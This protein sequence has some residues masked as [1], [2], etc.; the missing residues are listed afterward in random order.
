[1]DFMTM[2]LNQA[3]GRCY[4]ESITNNLNTFMYFKRDGVTIDVFKH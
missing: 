3:F 2:E 4:D 1:M